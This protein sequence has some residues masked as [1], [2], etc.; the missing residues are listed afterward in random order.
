M[1]ATPS[2]GVSMDIR[3]AFKYSFIQQKLKTLLYFITNI[4]TKPG[5]RGVHEKNKNMLIFKKLL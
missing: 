3:S 2:F 1:D 4:S 5:R